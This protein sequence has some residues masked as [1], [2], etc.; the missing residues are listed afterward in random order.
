MSAALPQSPDQACCVPA[1]EDELEVNIPG[2]AGADGADGA[3]GDDGLNAFTTAAAGFTM[4][5]E[6]GEVVVATTTKT[7]FLA[8]NQLVYVEEAGWM[9]V[10]SLPS[11]FSVTLRNEEDTGTA[12]YTENAAPGTAISAGAK[13]S[14]GGL[15]GPTGSAAGALLAANNLNDVANPTTSRA[16]LGVA[17][18]TDVQ[19]WDADL[20]T[21]AGITPSANVQSLLGAANYAAMRTQLALVIGTDVQA[22]DADLDSVAAGITAAGLALIDDASAT[23]QRTTLGVQRTLQDYLL[24]EHQAATT[25]NG[26]T[27]T[28]GAWQ[29][30]PLSTEVVDTGAHGAIAASIITLQAGTYRYRGRVCGYKVDN[31]QSRLFNVDTATPI[32]YGS[33][34]TAAN[35]ATEQVYSHIAGRFTLAIATQVRLEARCSTTEANDGFGLANSFGGTEIYSGIEFEREVG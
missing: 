15:Q 16:N 13:I 33:N 19:A 9:R 11:D 21:Y 31:F 8:L 14:P 7:T 26:G 18:G 30:V 17:I 2:P 6:A 25:V 5:A 12:A 10:T 24:Y 3:D 29:T 32:N 20:D 23:A 28:S 22:W 27:F 34:A 35:A 4:P 1:C